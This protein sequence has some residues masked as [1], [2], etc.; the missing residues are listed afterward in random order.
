MKHLIIVTVYDKPRITER[1]LNL[2]IRNTDLARDN[3]LCV[4]DDCS[5][6]P[7]RKLLEQIQS[8][9][10]AI[11]LHR[12]TRNTGKPKSVNW[13]MRRY[14]NMDYYTVID[15]DVFVQDRN[16]V[17]TLFRAHRDWSNSAILGAYTYMTGFAI[18]KNGRRYL[19]PWPFWNLAGC[20]FSFSRKVY[21]KLGYFSEVSSRSEDA[22]YCRRAYLGGFRWFYVPGIKATITGSKG[23]AEKKR[24]RRI[25][26]RDAKKRRGYDDYIML[27]HD[28][29]F[30]PK[31]KIGK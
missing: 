26:I 29:H 6:L 16:W 20:F 1:C 13:A 12:N 25:H 8:R 18:T 22:N 5:L 15:S 31:Y 9:Y 11:E 19:D 2:L 21:K 17:A 14:P 27:T 3:K 30:P 23:A 7:T 24:Q 28:V 10:P 4:V